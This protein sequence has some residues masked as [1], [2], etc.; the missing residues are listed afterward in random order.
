M[1]ALVLGCDWDLGMVA[2]GSISGTLWH[3]NNSIFWFTWMP[4]W[5]SLIPPRK[6]GA[7]SLNPQNLSQSLH[8]VSRAPTV[9]FF[10]PSFFFL[11]SAPAKGCAAD[12]QCNPKGPMESRLGAFQA[13][14][15]IKATSTSEYLLRLL[16]MN[17][18]LIP[19]DYIVAFIRRL[20]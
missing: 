2:A 9:S 1:P 13:L 6:G 8:Q 11:F 20:I 3:D 4:K 5:L 12:K 15:V 10:P 18:Y 19:Q 16:I 7:F 14:A 17:P